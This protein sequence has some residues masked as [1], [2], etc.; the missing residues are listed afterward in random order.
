MTAL[1]APLTHLREQCP[2]EQSCRVGSPGK[3]RWF[4]CCLFVLLDI[5]PASTSCLSLDLA[6]LSVEGFNRKALSGWCPSQ[7]QLAP[8][9]GHG[10]LRPVSHTVVGFNHKFLPSLLPGSPLPVA[11]KEWGWKQFFLRSASFEIF[12]FLIWVGQE[13][14]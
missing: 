8:G 4:V 9:R 12:K 14:T 13:R 5:E 1:G 2:A 3:R 10:T 7:G 11:N 6:V